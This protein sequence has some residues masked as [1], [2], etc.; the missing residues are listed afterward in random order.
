MVLEDDFAGIVATSRTKAWK[1][2]EKLELEWEGGLDA[3]QTELE[4]LVTVGN[5][6][7]VIIQ[8]EGRV[9]ANLSDEVITAE[10]RSPMAAHAHL[11]P[12]AAL[13]DVQPDKV[14]ALVSTQSPQLV[15]GELAELLGYSEEE[16]E[17]TPAYL[18][19]GFGRKLNVAVALEA[20]RLSRAVGKPVHVGWN[21]SEEFRSGYLRPPTHSV[22]R[23]S[24]DSDGTITAIEHE[25]AS[26]D[27]A[28]PF[29]PRLAAPILGADFGAWRGA[30][31]HYGGIEHRRAV[32]YRTPLPLRTGWWRGLGLLANTFA[33]ESFMDELARHAGADP[34]AFRLRHLDNSEEGQ[35]FKKVL[36]AAADAAGWDT[37][38][39]EGR[40]RGIAC[41]T[42]VGTVVAQV[43]EVSVEDTQV[44]VHRVTCAVDPGFIV[45][46]DGVKAQTQGAIV[47]GLSSTLKE[48]INVE[49][50]TVAASN[51]DRYPLLTMA[52]T[53]ELEVVL[54]ESSDTPTG[55][56]EPPIGP[57]AAATANAVAALT[58]QRLR[59]LPLK[60]S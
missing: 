19:G 26:G 15:Q 33:V 41:S 45:N 21:R 30:T 1:A 31:L 46:P 51:F 53:P 23:A 43:A 8:R 2:L 50:G 57:V 54:L 59:T 6:E 47:M 35:R 60:L 27:V 25:Q 18:G 5:G 16:V 10:Y 40:A 11:E 32:S 13:V 39:P 48:A 49:D 17:V 58:G 36:Q 44:R 20:A 42:D 52:E 7:R 37:P 12:Q 24:L 9:G 22:L 3:D 34:L 38:A 14:T 28:F 29:F 4:R 56:G 55:M